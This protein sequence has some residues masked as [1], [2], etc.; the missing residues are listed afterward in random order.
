[1]TAGNGRCKLAEMTPLGRR[2]V[3]V[4]L[5]VLAAC[6]GKLVSTGAP[7]TSGGPA[8]T[9]SSRTRTL[10]DMEVGPSVHPGS[11]RAAGKLTDGSGAPVVGATVTVVL[12]SV[13]SSTPVTFELGTRTTDE[14]GDFQVTFHLP[15]KGTF[16]VE[17]RFGGDARHAGASDQ[18]PVTGT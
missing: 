8:P 9:S 3:L 13:G 17:A 16:L 12:T 14:A 2:A 10:L 4:P 11:F 15:Q 7:A 1:L 5:L 6:T 18:G